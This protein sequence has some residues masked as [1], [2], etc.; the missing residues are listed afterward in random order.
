MRCADR[1]AVP[2]ANGNRRSETGPRLPSP[3]SS[4]AE[5]PGG[6]KVCGLEVEP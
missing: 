5:S 3:L 4:E 6:S 1:S 2:V